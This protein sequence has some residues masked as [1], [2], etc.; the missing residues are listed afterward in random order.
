MDFSRADQI[1][2]LTAAYDVYM[3]VLQKADEG[4]KFYSTLFSLVR[5]LDEAMEGV[6]NACSLN[7][8]IW[9]SGVFEVAIFSCLASILWLLRVL[10][11]KI[12]V[13]VGGNN[14]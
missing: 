7:S 12:V 5:T 2:A 13:A 10:L 3:D 1:L 14:F 9:R 6:E 8:L 4:L 11:T